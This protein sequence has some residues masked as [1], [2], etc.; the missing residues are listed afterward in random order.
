MKPQDTQ[1]P[2]TR[3]G[4]SMTRV[5]G[6]ALVAQG[7]VP[8]PAVSRAVAPPPT[9]YELALSV[10]PKMGKPPA[11]PAITPP[12]SR[13][14]SLPAVQPRLMKTAANQ[15]IAKPPTTPA[16]L[17]V[18]PAPRFGRPVVQRM[19]AELNEV[20]VRRYYDLRIAE[21][22]NPTNPKHR[23][24][25]NKILT[26]HGMT[27]EGAK[28][29]IRDYIIRW[30]S[31]ID[32]DAGP[33]Q[34]PSPGIRQPLPLPTNKPPVELSDLI[35]Q[36]VK[37]GDKELQHFN[38][39]EYNKLRLWG[40][41]EILKRICAEVGTTAYEMIT[42][43]IPGDEE[44]LLFRFHKF[45]IDTASYQMVFGGGVNKSEFDPELTGSSVKKR[46]GERAKFMRNLTELTGVKKAKL[47]ESFQAG[48]LNTPFIATTA[49]FRYTLELATHPTYRAK[50]GQR[51]VIL[52]IRGPKTRV[53]DFESEFEALKAGSKEHN[54]RTRE[55]RA[56]DANQKEYGIGDLYIPMY[57]RSRS[58]F[59]I[60]G[61]IDV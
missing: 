2:P 39:K 31:A 16:K 26:A 30:K 51:G 50:E 48:A 22:G 57:G 14:G 4:S 54:Y 59:Q 19:M 41:L 11:S 24:A 3:F 23:T 35:E 1:P 32:A 38:F 61:M 9:R 44:G 20:E 5:P 58:G 29:A 47:M 53:F 17:P 8:N 46:L 49:D 13:S 28:E 12:P 43:L 27:T 33:E 37:I 6:P 45:P 60:I 7:K 56:K 18:I 42:P 34:P 40:R 25:L 36:H 15:A 10:Q 21:I 52:V 55:N